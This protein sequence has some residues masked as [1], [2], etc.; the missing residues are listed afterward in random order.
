MVF[1]SFSREFLSLNQISKVSF[2]CRRS[3]LHNTRLARSI[4]F[5]TTLIITHFW[6]DDFY[7]EDYMKILNKAFCEADG[8]YIVL[9]SLV[10][11]I[12]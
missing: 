6:L 5:A 1:I 10:L 8:S 4:R 2:D 12:S 3:A 9:T 7:E 11:C